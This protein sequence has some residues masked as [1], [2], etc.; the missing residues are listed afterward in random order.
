MRRLELLAP[1]RGLQTG[2]AAIDC[3]AD[4]VYIGAEKFGARVAAGNSTDDIAQ[5]VV[6]A[7]RFRAKVYVALNTIVYDS[8]L[9]KMRELIQQM[10]RIGV[11]A[12]LVQD[13]AMLR[14]AADAGIPLHASTQTDNR[15]IEMVGWLRERGFTRVV[16]ARE[17]SLSEIRAI[18]EACPD[19]E[20]ETFVHGALCVSFSGACYASQQL[21]ARSA[22]RGACCQVCRMKFDLVDARGAVICRGAHLL[23]LKDLNLISHLEELADAGVCSFKI[24]GRLKDEVYVKNVVAAYSQ[25]LDRL[26]R[27]RPGD[28]E[29]SSIGVVDYMFTPDLNKTFHRGYTEY[30]FAGRRDDIANHSTP[31]ATGESVGVVKDVTDRYIT[32]A[33][34]ASFANG[35]GLCFVNSSNEMEG[36]RVNRAE[37]NRLFPHVMPRTLV[38]GTP[39]YRNNDI[40][41]ERQLSK[42]AATR[43]IPLRLTYRATADGFALRAEGRRMA[44]V[45]AEVTFAHEAAKKPQ[46]ANIREQLGR[47]G[48]TIYSIENITI[49]DDAEKLF[50][51]SSLLSSLRQTLSK[52][53][54]EQASGSRTEK[55]TEM[56]MEKRT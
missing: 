34:V 20:I 2:I 29:R 46:G 43:R 33:G 42:R 52:R 35:D 28:Y 18:H 7:H 10:S 15:S 9:D 36:F 49:E 16:L 40:A 38:K 45:E 19:I 53:L 55:T 39:L 6:Y 14:L 51:P 27:R 3:G 26:C 56:E 25:A 1:A 50:I 21:F 37:G 17:L 31:K 24:E 48:G 13:M 5:L 54:D 30:F 8:E 44:A 32:V 22:N 4:A 12:I 47:W 11:D 41:F 23:S